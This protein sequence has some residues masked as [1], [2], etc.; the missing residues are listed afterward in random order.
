MTVIALINDRMMGRP[1]GRRSSAPRGLSPSLP[2]AVLS[3]LLVSIILVL[4]VTH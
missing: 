2:L 1:H 3:I 4:T